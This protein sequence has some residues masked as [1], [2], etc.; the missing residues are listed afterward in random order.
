MVS[1]VPGRISITVGSV[2]TG[3]IV[4]GGVVVGGTVGLV[5]GAVVVLGVVVT[6]VSALRQPVSTDSARTSA[7][8]KMLIFFI[9]KPPE[10][11]DFKASISKHPAFILGTFVETRSFYHIFIKN[12][13]L[14]LL[15]FALSSIIT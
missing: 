5:V 8:A 14:A 13:F 6:L 12:R 2:V 3:G 1:S 7:N 9:M 10:I 15:F 4:V 11:S